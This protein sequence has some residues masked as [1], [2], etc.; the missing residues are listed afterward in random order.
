MNIFEQVDKFKRA[1]DLTHPFE[2]K[3]LEE[4]RAYYRVKLT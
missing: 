2:G 4:I 3:M 1:V